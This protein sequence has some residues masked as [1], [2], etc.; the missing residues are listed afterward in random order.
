MNRVHVHRDPL[1][2]KPTE[3]ENE[4]WAAAPGTRGREEKLSSPPPTPRSDARA[5]LLCT[6]RR[7]LRGCESLPALHRH[8]GG[9]NFEN[10]PALTLGQGLHSLER[11]LA[12]GESKWRSGRRLRH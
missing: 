11:R 2:A 5:R 1:L 7:D 4:G 12:H 9:P 6:L 8:Q 10:A 3:K